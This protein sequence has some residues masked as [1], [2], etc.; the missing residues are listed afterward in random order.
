MREIS[1]DTWIRVLRSWLCAASLLLKYQIF[2]RGKI[3]TGRRA[4]RRLLDCSITGRGSCDR[5]RGLL[6]FSFWGLENQ[7]V[8][9]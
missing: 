9:V 3:R 5:F 8:G 1:A 6:K 7:G 4:W 2:A